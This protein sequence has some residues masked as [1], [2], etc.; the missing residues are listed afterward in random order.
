MAASQADAATA[1][2]AAAVAYQAQ[3][4]RLSQAAVLASVA[5]WQRIDG[6]A[7]DASWPKVLARMLAVITGAQRK[8]AASVPGYLDRILKAQH[9]A[10]RAALHVNPDAFAGLTGDGRNLA[11][12]LYTPVALSKQRIGQGE[13]IADV[14]RQESLHVAVLAKTVVQDTQRQ[15]LQTSMAAEPVIRGYVRH[16]DLPSCPRCIILAGRFYRKSSGFLRH[17]NDDCTMIPAVGEKWVE[18]Q[19]PEKLFAE[20]R[21]KHPEHLRKSLTEGD[22]RALDHGANLNQ[23]VNAHRG[24]TTAAGMQVTTEGTTRRGTAGKR[25]GAKRGGHVTRLTPAQIFDEADANGWGED[26]ILRQ[27]KRFSYITDLPGSPGC[28]TAALKAGMPTGL[29]KEPS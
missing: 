7:L 12:L 2:Q 4:A 10:S 15:A 26:E 13:R 23:V 16:L 18:A 9:V 29:R 27:L 5:A 28:A 22:L 17:P 11:G 8:A 25:L 6:K 20:M 1:S 24:M 21:E 19:D 14:I 3:Q